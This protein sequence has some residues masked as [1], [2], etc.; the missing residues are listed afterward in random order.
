MA[1]GTRK[2]RLEARITTEQKK[3]FMRAAELQGT[4][5]TEFIMR[6]L[7]EAAQRT[8]KEHERLELDAQERELFITSLLNP[9]APSENLRKAN[10]RYR[11]IMDE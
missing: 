10:E 9:P 11:A 2:E 5:L 1:A 4:S 6:N 3:L 7:Q 8:I